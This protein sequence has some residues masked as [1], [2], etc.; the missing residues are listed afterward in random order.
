MEFIAD[1]DNNDAEHI[2][3]HPSTLESMTSKAIDL[4]GAAGPV[5]PE[6]SDTHRGEFG[7]SIV[8]LIAPELK[9]DITG[10]G[11]IPRISS[12]VMRQRQAALEESAAAIKKAA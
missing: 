2:N 7:E 8:S 11:A 5:S 9:F 1:P 4:A 10:P 12:E 3:L 6:R